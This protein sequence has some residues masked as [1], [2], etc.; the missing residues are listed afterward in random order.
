MRKNVWRGSIN[1]EVLKKCF[2]PPIGDGTSSSRLICT[3][4]EVVG[5]LP[6]QSISCCKCLGHPLQQLLLCHSFPLISQWG[7]VPGPPESLRLVGPL[8]G[9]L[10]QKRLG[11]ELEMP[12]HLP[13]LWFSLHRALCP[14]HRAESRWPPPPAMRGGGRDSSPR[15]RRETYVHSHCS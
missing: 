10:L 3:G 6:L 14:Q 5:V 4:R 9:M 15:T 7:L 11:P 2:S 13:Q 1:Y 12:R 8:P